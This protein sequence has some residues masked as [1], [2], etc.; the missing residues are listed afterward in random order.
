MMIK[1]AIL[2]L[3]LSVIVQP[4]L[5]QQAMPIIKATSTEI[6]ILDG[7]DLLHGGLAP[8]LK[9]DTYV[10]HR[11]NKEKKIV[12][13]TDLDSIAFNV[14]LGDTYTFAVLLNNKD[15]CYQ[16]FSSEN[17]IGVTYLSVSV[18]DTIPFVLGTDNAIHIKGKLNNSEMLDL[19]FD[20]GASIGVLSDKGK[21]KNAM[22]NKDD[23][24]KF[25]FA[26]ITIENSPAIFVD[27]NGGLK[28]DGVIGYNAFENKV[29][30]INYD[31]NIM[32]IH[33]SIDAETSSYSV[34]EMVWRGSGLYID[35][36]LKSNSEQYNGLFLFDTGSK[37]AISA[38]KSFAL[39]NNLYDKMPKIG[40]R[41]GK[42]VD[43]K[44]IKSNTVTLPQF[45]IGA[46]SLDNVPLD[47]ELPSDG[48]GLS[49]NILG[50]DVLKRFNVILD[51]QNGLIYLKSNS[52]TNAAY[53]ESFDENIFFLV[54]GILI[55]LMA[56]GY[57]LYRNRNARQSK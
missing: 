6:K 9:P 51:Y 33:D 45:L 29:V 26:G 42:G 44:S 34:V 19:I 4:L 50:N 18:K 27:Y 21:G 41:R 16:K 57:I 2:G 31:Q 17:P 5:A 20:T 10:Y 25:E 8:E 30:E 52:L 14:T 12:F 43:G 53:N 55:G 13:Y 40:T 49:Y 35:C 7:D 54:G 15:T 32:I 38:T 46:L 3:I 1:K 56:I 48:G 23:K 11:S 22:L 24:N 47:L 28:A 39:K 36:V 37:W